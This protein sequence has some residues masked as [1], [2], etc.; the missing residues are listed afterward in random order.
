MAVPWGATCSV[1]ASAW[2]FCSRRNRQA[3]PTATR[4]QVPAN[5]GQPTGGLPG[6]VRVAP[7]LP[8]STHNNFYLLSIKTGLGLDGADGGW[9]L[10]RPPRPLAQR[11][12]C[13][14]QSQEDC[15]PRGQHGG[16][17]GVAR[18]WEAKG[19]TTKS[20]AR[21]CCAVM[22]PS[23]ESPCPSLASPSPAL[24]QPHTPPPAFL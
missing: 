4:S 22:E 13:K 24:G 18:L 19:S 8:P 3:E 9:W 1:V 21:V 10:G 14:E 17:G 2:W 5:W 11:A 20:Q 7:P 15:S 23:P 12:C 16:G 6:T